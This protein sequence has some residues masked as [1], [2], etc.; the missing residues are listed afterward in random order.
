MCRWIS[1]NK[2]SGRLST[3]MDDMNDVVVQDKAATRSGYMFS[4]TRSAAFPRLQ[5]SPP[6][7]FTSCSST[8][9]TQESSRTR[10]DGEFL[11]LR[12]ARCTL[13]AR[14]GEILEGL[15]NCK[16]WM[17][18]DDVGYALRLA[19][20]VL[21]MGESANP[22]TS[23]LDFYISMAGNHIRS[24]LTFNHFHALPHDA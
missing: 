16:G 4:V 20:S 10:R 21:A 3:A 8:P 15:M 5:L 11:L 14:S 9:T 24:M 7:N 6:T 2:D 17:A 22:T 18:K 23:I 12:D 1:S 19:R 13:W